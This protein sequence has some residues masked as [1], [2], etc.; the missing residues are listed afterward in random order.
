MAALVH[1]VFFQLNDPTPENS[2]KLV[3]ACHKYLDNHPGVTYFA[4]GGLVQELDRPVNQR[5]F[6]VALCVAFATKEDHDVY[7]T[8]PR[9]LEFIAE[10]KPSWKAVRVFDSWAGPV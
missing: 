1:N 9:H 4:A 2:R 8:A 10:N 5:D 3:E 7:Q 6:D